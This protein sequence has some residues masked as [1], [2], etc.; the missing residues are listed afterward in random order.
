MPGHYQHKH[1]H[2]CSNNH[3]SIPS[4]TYVYL[5]ILD[6][7]WLSVGFLYNKFSS[8]IF[9]LCY[10]TLFIW[11]TAKAKA[12][13]KAKRS[14]VFITHW[15]FHVST[16]ISFAFMLKKLSPMI[17]DYHRLYGFRSYN[18]LIMLPYPLHLSYSKGKGKGKGKGR[19]SS[20]VFITHWTFHVSTPIS[21]AFMLKKLSPMIRD[22]HRL[23]D[24]QVI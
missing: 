15:T 10:H 21:F 9:S 8:T 11:L 5:F 13:A 17:R 6:V 4:V 19:G 14:Y 23:Y 1:C 16:P 12:K 3:Y 20:Y 24:F 18:I 2:Y 7:E 22:Y